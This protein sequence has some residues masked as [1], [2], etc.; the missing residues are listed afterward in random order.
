MCAHLFSAIDTLLSAKKLMGS[1]IDLAAIDGGSRKIELPLSDGQKIPGY[2]WE[3]NLAN[4]TIIYFYDLV[5][6]LDSVETITKGLVRQ[7]LNVLIPDYAGN[8]SLP[9]SALLL[10]ASDM[11]SSCSNW[12]TTNNF[13][14]PLFV[15]GRSLGGIVAMEIVVQNSQQLKG[16]FLE[17][18][19]CDTGSFLQRATGDSD[20][21]IAESEG[22]SS[23]EKIGE[24]TLPTMIFHGAQ[25]S[26]VSIREA[27][28]LQSH[29]GAKNKQFFVIPRAERDKLAE[30]GGEL[31][32]QTI[33]K[34]IDGVIGTNTWREKRRKFKANAQEE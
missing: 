23:L 15:M 29:C 12:L 34:F 27:E 10:T 13:D 28:K 18:P 31:Y 3:T 7:N 20:I 8:R 24:I 9:Y 14:G 25:D 17:S 19:I 11:F 32:F 21:E 26:L 4:P 1:S 16:F 33:K 6:D 5:S 2:L 22:F 30:S